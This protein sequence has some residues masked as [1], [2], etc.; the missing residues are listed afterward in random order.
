[1]GNEFDINKIFDNVEINGIKE[2]T[3]EGLKEIKE[4]VYKM[5]DNSHIA[6]TPHA[7]TVALVYDAA[8]SGGMYI[9]YV[10]KYYMEQWAKE[11]S[12]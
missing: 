8:N 11:R 6:G 2:K 4:S 7:L 9:P 12:A 3:R 5:M 1:M 10:T